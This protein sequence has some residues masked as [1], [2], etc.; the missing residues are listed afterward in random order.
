MMKN[1]RSIQQS[2]SLHACVLAVALTFSSGSIILAQPDL[3]KGKEAFENKNYYGAERFF[4]E[5]TGKNPDNP[6]GWYYLGRVKMA[7]GENKTAIDLFERAIDLDQENA[8]YL[9]WSGINYIHVLSQV[10]FMEQGLYAYRAMN[11]LEKAVDLDP[12]NLEARIWLAGYYA[13]APSFAGGSEADAKDQLAEIFKRDPDHIGG[14]LQQGEILSVFGE[15]EAAMKSYERII[16]LDAEFFPVYLNIGRLVMQSG[17][18]AGKG[19]SALIHF[20][21]DSPAEFDHARDHAWYCLGNIYEKEGK[22][23]EARQSYEKAVSLNP[24]EEEYQ[25]SLKKV[26]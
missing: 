11:T 16:E 19:I 18:D 12:D 23:D 14:L 20:I 4:T 10:N 8:L 5:I 25:K 6:E 24:D 15:Y 21:H 13:N 9:T 7:K 3:S 2:V 17:M 26:M 22:L 1:S